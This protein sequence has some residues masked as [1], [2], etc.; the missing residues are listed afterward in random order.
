[1]N[2]AYM[3]LKLRN[4]YS[5][6]MFFLAYDYLNESTFMRRFNAKTIFFQTKFRKCTE[7]FKAISVAIKKKWRQDNIDINMN[8]YQK[9]THRVMIEIFTIKF[10][11]NYHFKPD[12]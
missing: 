3:L 8:S 1:M 6:N 12:D 11:K 7:L 10:L 5:V 9:T 4:K 2:Q